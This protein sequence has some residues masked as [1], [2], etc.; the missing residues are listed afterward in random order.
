MKSI[1][2][3]V[4]KAIVPIGQEVIDVS[5]AKGRVVSET[6]KSPVD[7]PSYAESLRDGYVITDPPGADATSDK[8]KLIGEIAAGTTDIPKLA[9]SCCCRIF[10]GGVIP[11]GGERVVPFEH[12][13]ERSGFLTVEDQADSS[14]RS[15]IRAKG[16]DVKKGTEIVAAGES[17]DSEQIALLLAL[18]VQSVSVSRLPIVASYCTGSE[19]LQPGGAPEKG[20]KTSVNGWILADQLPKYGGTLMRSGL[21]R[22]DYQVLE[23]TLDDAADGSM[24]VVVTT[25]G[26]GPGKYDLV[27]RAFL[28]VGGDVVLESLPIRPGKSIFLGILNNVIFVGL[29]GPPHAVRTLINEFVGPLLLLMQGATNCWPNVIEAALLHDLRKNPPVTTYKSGILSFQNGRCKV[30]L[31]GVGET[32]NCYVILEPSTSGSLREGDTVQ[33]HL[34][35]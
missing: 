2:E 33:L 32:A 31:A 8:Y 17:L 5:I 19:L 29:P 7:F 3:Q 18:H 10:T 30:R 4:Q 26:M 34:I 12:C 20:M 15:Y 27:K 23:K 24:D 9:D 16:S 6:I 35:R 13:I 11:E 14:K 22:D 1:R 21:L 25:G 28:A